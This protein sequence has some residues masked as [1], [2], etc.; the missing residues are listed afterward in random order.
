[1]DD[2]LYDEFGVY[3]GPDLDD[4]DEVLS[5]PDQGGFEASNGAEQ[6]FG[7]RMDVGTSIGR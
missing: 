7:A 5:E 2:N 6:N 1:M 3:I 4:D